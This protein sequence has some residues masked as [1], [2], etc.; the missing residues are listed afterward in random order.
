MNRSNIRGEKKQTISHEN[1]SRIDYSRNKAMERSITKGSRL[2]LIKLEKFM[3]K[4]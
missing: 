4:I 3:K 2:K 1:T